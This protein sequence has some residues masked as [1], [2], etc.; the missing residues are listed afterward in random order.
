M[1]RKLS[2]FAG[3]WGWQSEANWQCLGKSFNIKVD[4]NDDL[5]LQGM[6]YNARYKTIELWGYYGKEKTLPIVYKNDDLRP[7][8]GPTN[9]GYPEG[10]PTNGS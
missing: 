1:L 7:H 3:R 4:V 9:I 8:N 5:V 10:A 2:T 6:K